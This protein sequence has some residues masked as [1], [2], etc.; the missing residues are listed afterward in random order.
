VAEQAT[1]AMSD[2]ES[3]LKYEEDDLPDFR[4]RRFTWWFSGVRAFDSNTHHNLALTTTFVKP[5]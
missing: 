3:E 1:K 2:C 4:G 5:R